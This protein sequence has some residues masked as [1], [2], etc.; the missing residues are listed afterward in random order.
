[1]ASAPSGPGFDYAMDNVFINKPNIQKG[2]SMYRTRFHGRYSQGMKTAR[3]IP[4]N[5]FF[6]GDDAAQDAT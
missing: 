3:R 4:S 2:N 5:T 1:M 6:L